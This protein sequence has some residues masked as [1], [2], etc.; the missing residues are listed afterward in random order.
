MGVALGMAMT[1]FGARH[2]IVSGWLA[3]VAHGLVACP[4]ASPGGGPPS[5]F[6]SLCF[7]LYGEGT[8]EVLSQG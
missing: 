5:P 3:S 1:L 2:G 7:L 6:V 8:N 4:V